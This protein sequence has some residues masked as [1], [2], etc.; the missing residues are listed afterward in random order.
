MVD[1]EVEVL[2]PRP[3]PPPDGIDDPRTDA[4]A[5]V[6]GGR[7]RRR[8]LAP[9]RAGAASVTVASARTADGCP[10]P[11]ITRGREAD[12][13]HFDCPSAIRAAPR[14]LAR[15]EIYRDRSRDA[16]TVRS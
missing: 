9:Q 2:Y 10:P 5:P 3:H 7:L 11:A 14:R 8:R 6:V 12:P 16:V 1:V 4:D 15:A 13:A